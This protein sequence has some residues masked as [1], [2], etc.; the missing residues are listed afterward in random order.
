MVLRMYSIEKTDLV[1]MYST[2][3]VQNSSENLSGFILQLSVSFLLKDMHIYNNTIY[4]HYYYIYVPYAYIFSQN[5]Y[6]ANART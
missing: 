3:I 4:K 6:F 2:A 5:V 1:S